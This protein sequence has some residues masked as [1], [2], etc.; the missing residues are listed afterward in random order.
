MLIVFGLCLLGSFS[1]TIISHALRSFKKGRMD[2]LFK[3]VGKRLF[4]PRS[5]IHCLFLAT[6]V[7]KYFLLFLG[8]CVVTVYV[9]QEAKLTE[10]IL[11]L[12][13]ALFLV[14]IIGDFL[15]K[16]FVAL[17]PTR[18][19]RIFTPIASCFL[20][21]TSPL[22]FIFFKLPKG[23]A[24]A[25]SFEG[26]ASSSFHVNE[27]IIHM[28]EDPKVKASLDPHNKKLITAVL[29]FKDRI[30][31]EVMIPRVSVFS[32]PSTNT[33]RSAAEIL[34]VEGYSRVP[35]YKDSIDSIIG[36]LMYKDIFNDTIKCARGELPATHLDE[37]IETLL[38]PVFYTP[39]TK[40]VSHLLQ[41]FR[42]K[43]IHLAVVVDEYGG[44]EGIV[45]IEDIL[46]EI[47]GDISDEYDDAK[48]VLYKKGP[49]GS[50]IVDAKMSI[51][52]IEENFGIHIPQDADY[53]T[54]GGYIYH[55]AG[56]IPK[57]GFHIYHDAF[58]VEVLSST[59]RSV[60][61]VRITSRNLQETE[62]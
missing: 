2:A 52:E 57:S 39:E 49:E 9:M 48:E 19:L 23:I 5:E 7:A 45:T 10:G 31:R 42:N 56:A 35:V 58:D 1:L 33:I 59:D 53:D 34:L 29:N 11:L 40:K 8:A 38:K 4:F 47:V 41:E 61:Q 22:T 21:I 17:K 50:W 62:D 14:L 28:L 26:I 55:K 3:D 51:L 27:E 16:L 13:F 36:I 18:A 37:S 15:P 46:E 6:L 44:T 43:Q 32:I 25:L 20:W 60:G 24:N 30:V 54:L 12:F